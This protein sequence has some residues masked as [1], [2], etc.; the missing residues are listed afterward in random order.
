MAAAQTKEFSVGLS[1]QDATVKYT[2]RPA[3]YNGVKGRI[4]VRR[5]LKDG[6]WLHSGSMHIRSAATDTEVMAAF[7][8]QEV[9]HE[10]TDAYWNQ[11]Q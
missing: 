7:D 9:D 5:I 1:G 10:A 8:S 4:W 6:A 11:N 3:T 2:P